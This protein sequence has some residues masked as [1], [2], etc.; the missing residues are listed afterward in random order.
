MD[1]QT[2]AFLLG[3]FL[4]AALVL[5]VSGSLV[6]LA[7]RAKADL[8]AANAALRLRMWEARRAIDGRIASVGQEAKAELQKL[9]ELL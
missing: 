4:G 2:N 5:A 9:K 7:R 8:H 1:A 6:V 3:F